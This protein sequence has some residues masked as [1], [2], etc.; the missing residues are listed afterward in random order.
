M[1]GRYWTTIVF[2]I[3]S[4]FVLFCIHEQWIILA[5]PSFNIQKDKINNCVYTKKTVN[6]TFYK[7]NV[8]KKEPI[9]CII[10]PDHNQTLKTII[11]NWFT[12]IEEEKQIDKKIIADSVA[13]AP[14][15]KIA[16]ISL[17]QNPFNNQSIADKI[18]FIEGL[19]ITTSQL[20]IDLKGIHFFIQHEPFK[21]YHLDFSEPWLIDCTFPIINS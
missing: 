13:I 5:V 12:L 19:L 6:Y 1:I 21:D 9:E 8:L 17:N 4:G 14:Q 11:N 16:Y 10:T 3:V 7:E 15:S 18:H 20:S 2:L